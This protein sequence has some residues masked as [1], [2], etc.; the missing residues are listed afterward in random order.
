MH[1]LGTSP[2]HNLQKLSTK[3]GP[4]MS[5][6]LGQAQCVVAS[7]TETAM[8]FLK[9]QDSNFTSRP[10]L[11]VGEAVFYGQ[12]L[13]FQNSTPLWRHLKKIFQVEFTSTK[14]LDTTRH[15]REEEIAHLTSTLPHNC[16]VNLRIH[17]KSMIGNIISRMAVG[18]RLC[19]KP[20]ECE[21]EEQLREVAS[22]REVMD[23]VAFC[24]GAV[25]LA[26]YIPALKWLDLQGLER[27]F[28]KT[29]Q[30]M[31]SV[32]GE[33]IAK[34]QERRKLSNPT[35]KQKDLIDVLLDDMEKPQD[36]SPRV[37]M[38]SIKAVTWNAFAGATDAIAMSLEWAMSE[39]L[40]HPHVQAKAHAELDVVVGKNRRVEESDIQNLSYIG[41][42]IKE[43]LRLHPVAPM[44]APH[45][46]LNPCKAFGF[47]IP[48]GTWVIINAWAIARD[49]AV[50]KD[51]TE[52]NPDRFMQDDPNALNPRVFEML[53]FGAGKRMCPG[54]AM[55]NVT[56]QRAIA[57][58]LH[59]FEWGLTSELDMSEGTMSI[60]VPR[61]VPLHAVAKPRLSSEFYT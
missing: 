5:I 25:N 11:R 23:N 59:E 57:K 19:A 58:L 16:E 31:N 33:I 6:R 39:I 26:D 46:A 32:S 20:E 21:S 35:D 43:T 41:A 9:N 15:V 34:H 30:I 42:I 36:G 1:L 7:S 60:V 48:G 14:R 50:W 29:F 55:A 37:T 52:F 51:P 24:I 12:D 45:A 8:E 10:A 49:P 61:A 28:K 44:L 53:P 38:D 2:H 27:R 18:Q 56:M 3:Y 17:L 40:L 47:D 54:V 22:L 13:V 4:L